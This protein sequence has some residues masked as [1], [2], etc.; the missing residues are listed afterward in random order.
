MD[1]Q[2]AAATAK[3]WPTAPTGTGILPLPPSVGP[4]PTGSA[5]DATAPVSSPG[6]SPAADSNSTTGNPAIGSNPGLATLPAQASTQTNDATLKK[7]VAQLYNAPEQNV[8]VS[9]QFQQGVNEIVTVFT[10]KTTGKVLVQFPSETLIALA[11]LFDQI[12]GNVVNKK[13]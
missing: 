9:F 12:D 10:D 6:G 11:K 13:V 4:N 5:P 2:T 7:A 3:I 1:V 8:S